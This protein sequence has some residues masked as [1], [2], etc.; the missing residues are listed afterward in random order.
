MAEGRNSQLTGALR[1]RG[2]GAITVCSD[3][4]LARIEAVLV[5]WTCNDECA[6]RHDNNGNEAEG[7]WRPLDVT[8]MQRC[9]SVPRR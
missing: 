4:A 7:V 8:L 3:Q 2:E 5:M 9:A 6:W 1:R